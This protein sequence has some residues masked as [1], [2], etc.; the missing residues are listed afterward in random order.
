MAYRVSVTPSVWV[1]TA[2]K[3]GYTLQSPVQM[4]IQTNQNIEL[5][6]LILT[7]NT[8]NAKGYVYNTSGI[9]LSAVVLT[10]TKGSIVY[11]KTTNSSGYFEF[12]GLGLGTWTISA[13]LP[14]YFAGNPQTLTLTATS[15]VMTTLA[16]FSLTPRANLINGT[17]SNG[18]IGLA[19]TTIRAIPA[20]GSPVETQTNEYG[21]YTLSVP[22][23]NYQII[24]L[25][26]GYTAQNTNQLN[27]TVGQTINAVNFTLYPNQSYIRGTISSGTTTLADVIVRA[28]NN[29]AVTNSSGYYS[30][31]VS[32]G[33]YNVIPEKNGYLAGNT[34]TISISDGQIVTNINFTMTPNAATISGKV[35]SNGSTVAG[36]II[37][38]YRIGTNAAITT[39]T[40]NGSGDYALSLLHGNYK[41]WA[42]K[43][44]FVCTDTLT[45]VVSPR[46]HNPKQTNKSNP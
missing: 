2:E 26:T 1:V 15:P 44:N 37:S 29:S 5:P 17:V 43:T 41:I 31:P 30:I 9:A 46:C 38:A 3:E 6:D 45:I 33:T 23:G 10:A 27:L 22:Q 11:Q 14:G 34:H 42:T 7:P 39:T 40:S 24:A 16:N 19:N 36:A 28:G 20:S 32:S 4:S 25:R 35:Q 13:D 12:N 8:K 18:T 21:N